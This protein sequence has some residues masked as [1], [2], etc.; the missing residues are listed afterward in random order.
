M[1]SEVKNTFRRRKILCLYFREYSHAAN[2]NHS[3]LCIQLHLLEDTYVLI[4]VFTSD[5]LSPVLDPSDLILTRGTLDEEDEEA[6]SDTDDIDHRG[7][8]W[9]KWLMKTAAAVCSGEY[10]C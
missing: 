8:K 1:M 3:C 10:H 7:E 5:S 4:G 9:L 2:D 6:D